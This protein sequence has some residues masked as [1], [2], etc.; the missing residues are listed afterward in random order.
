VTNKSIYSI[1]SKGIHELAEEE[2]LNAFPV[3]KLSIELILD[4]KLVEI[5]TQAKTRQVKTELELLQN[6]MKPKVK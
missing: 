6:K 1:L 2:C 5:Q 3:I 4:E